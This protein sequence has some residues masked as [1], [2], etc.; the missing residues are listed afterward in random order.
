MSYNI[1]LDLSPNKIKSPKNSNIKNIQ[2]KSPR[3]YS[4]TNKIEHI[5]I[6]SDRSS[7][8]KKEKLHLVPKFDKHKK[9]NNTF[10]EKDPKKLYLVI[11]LNY[12]LLIIKKVMKDINLQ[13]HFIKMKKLIKTL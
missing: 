9:L 2:I 6:N 13:V 7:T 5:M 4:Q 10:Y 11:I 1:R 12:L 3:Y 8:E